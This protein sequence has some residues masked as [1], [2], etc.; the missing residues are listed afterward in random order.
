M[1]IILSAI[2]AWKKERDVIKIQRHHNAKKNGGIKLEEFKEIFA[3]TALLHI[4][5]VLTF[6]HI[7]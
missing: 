5:A 2:N 1:F 3:Y 6:S 7:S 4:Y